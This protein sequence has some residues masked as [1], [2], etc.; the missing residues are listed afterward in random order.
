MQCTATSDPKFLKGQPSTQ[1][2]RA[3]IP[4][5]VMYV[6]ILT[7]VLLRIHSP[8]VQPDALTAASSP[9]HNL[10]KAERVRIRATCDG[11]D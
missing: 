5:M 6:G 4:E 10:F 11:A 2:Y 9:K 3:K 7:I 8:D 1:N